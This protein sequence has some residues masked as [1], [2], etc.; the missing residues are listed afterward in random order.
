MTGSIIR[1]STMNYDEIETIGKHLMA[2]SQYLDMADVMF[3][4]A[5]E[6]VTEPTWNKYFSTS[7]DDLEAKLAEINGLLDSLRKA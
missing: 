3:Q 4:S 7:K 2:I 6:K 5:V 1:E